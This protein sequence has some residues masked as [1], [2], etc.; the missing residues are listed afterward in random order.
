MDE[1]LDAYLG[2]LFKN[3]AGRRQAPEHIRARVL[4]LAAHP[5]VRGKPG[6]F[7]AGFKPQNYLPTNWEHFLLTC[8]IVHSNQNG[9]TVSRLVV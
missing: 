3:W 8:D 1:F 2:R 5:P 7:Y 9:L 4:S 6:D